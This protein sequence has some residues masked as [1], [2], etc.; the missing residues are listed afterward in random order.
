MKKVLLCMLLA[1]T[2]CVAPIT[3]AGASMENFTIKS[4]YAEY[5]TDVPP[6]AWFH[7]SVKRAYELGLVN[8]TSST[9]FSPNQT[10]TAEETTVLLARIHA[11]Y[12]DNQIGEQFSSVYWA[13]K[14]FD[15][16]KNNIDASYLGNGLYEQAADNRINF[17]YWIS[18]AL[19]STEYGEINTIPMGYI[20]DL[21]ADEFGAEIVNRIYMLYRAG[22]LTGSDVSGTFNPHS[23]ITRAEV[24]T[25]LVRLV[26][27]SKRVE[28]ENSSGYTYQIDTAYNIADVR[29]MLVDCEDTLYYATND[30]IYAD[31]EVVFDGYMP[32]TLQY[33][34]NTINYE[35]WYFQEL[36]TDAKHER[37]YALL[38]SWIRDS[39]VGCLM[40]I[41][42]KTGKVLGTS[43][44]PNY[45]FRRN[46]HDNSCTMNSAVID[47]SGA[48]IFWT[49]NRRWNFKSEPQ[50]FFV[51]N[52]STPDTYGMHL[53]Y[54]NGDLMGLGKELAMFDMN[55]STIKHIAVSTTEENSWYEYY[56]IPSDY[57]GKF[58][59]L[60]NKEFG[61]LCIDPST[62]TS[63]LMVDAEHVQIL[64]G[65]PLRGNAMYQLCNIMAAGTDY[66]YLFYPAD[67]CIR[68]LSPI[69]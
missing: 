21:S 57:N 32:I 40:A 34:T 49:G 11:I 1:F 26:D 54:S 50:I 60:G 15:Y 38:F 68:K 69:D 23:S 24:A 10:L 25:I 39:G 36:A 66:F 28:V 5:F 31:G 65:L 41:D 61:L 22:I 52:A 9:T 12:H 46:S 43:L 56:P 29:E 3:M 45:D 37:V 20:P 33:Q 53:G 47:P 19:P 58:Y 62:Q 63:N 16:V 2:I 48:L 51:G 14:Y 67:A 35:N 7:D 8:G 55:Q 17:A 64:D 44:S 4:A 6:N 59:T 13:N 18:Q 27:P 30:K 42:L